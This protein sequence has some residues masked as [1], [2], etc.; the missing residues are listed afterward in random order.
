MNNLENK[1]FAWAIGTGWDGEEK[2][3]FPYQEEADVMF[4]TALLYELSVLKPLA[5][6][7]LLEVQPNQREYSEATRLLKFF[8]YFKT[9]Q[10]FDIP[11]TSI[12]REFV[13]GSSFR[14]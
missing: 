12:L 7:I 2:H 3:I 11:P 1:E 10:T 4:N 9:I 14:Y 6:S 5:E 13:G 8:S